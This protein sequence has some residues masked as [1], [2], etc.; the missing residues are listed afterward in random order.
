MT[1]PYT[2]WQTRRMIYAMDTGFISRSSRAALDPLSDV[3]SLLK[4]HAYKSVGLDAG[5]DWAFRLEQSDGFMCLALVSGTCWIIMDGAHAPIRLNAGEFAVLPKAPGFCIASDPAVPA[6]SLSSA[7]EHW[8]KGGVVT[9]QGGGECL[10]L[11]AFFTFA[12]EHSNVLLEVLP[13]LLHLDNSVDCTAL[14][15]CLQRM[16]AVLRDPQPGSVLQGEYL[17]QLMLLEILRLHATGGVSPQVGWLSTLA[18]PQL[19]AAITAMH[20]LPAHRWTVQELAQRARM[21]RSAFAERFKEKA[22][23]SVMGYLVRWRMLLAA[24]RLSTSSE[25]VASIALSLGYDSESAF[26]FA[27]KREMGCSPRQYSKR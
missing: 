14:Q 4:P 2:L 8:P 15:W 25:P 5:R 3:L 27:F 11:S 10:L 1:S 24:D 18:D 23:T 12:S 16:M 19:G 17:A 7:I 9:W 13:P 22:G 26:G 20:Q 21:S 6:V